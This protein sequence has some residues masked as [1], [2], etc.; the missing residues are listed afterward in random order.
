MAPATAAL[1]EIFPSL[2]GEGFFAGQWHLFLRFCHCNLDCHY[3]DTDVSWTDHGKIYDSPNAQKADR[4]RNPI[5]VAELL[6]IIA[7]FKKQTSTLV[8]TGG[9]PL[10]W[11]EFLVELLPKLKRAKWTI[12]L[13]TNGTLST[14]FR[15]IRPWV[16]ILSMD[17]KLTPACERNSHWKTHHEFI[18][19]IPKNMKT[20][21][22]LI[23]D[24]HV[25]DHE[26][27]SVVS[28]LKKATSHP[29]LVLQPVSDAK[30]KLAISIQQLI[31]IQQQFLKSL[32][33]W[34]VRVL[35]QWHKILGI[36]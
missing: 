28:C 22:K 26:I 19:T 32:P 14:E 21:F 30:G 20:Y 1:R 18:Q 3:C 29:Q 33:G 25:A 4:F 5:S 2:Q 27:Q 36:K 17:I 13:E 6:P 31:S 10:L 8:L 23:V 11:K 35:P 9:E 12:L 15:A 7:R 16:D 34:D 24:N